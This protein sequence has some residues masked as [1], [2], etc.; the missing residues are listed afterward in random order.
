M[1]RCPKCGR[2]Y[3]D[4]DLNFCYEDGELLSYT[5]EDAPA[6]GHTGRPSVTD[7][8]P[9]TE[10]LPSARVTSEDPW[11]SRQQPPAV[12]QPSQMDGPFSQFPTR[13]VPNQT[14]GIVAL[15]LG[16]SSLTIG[17]CCSSGFVLS[18]AALIVGF[19]ALSQIKKDPQ[20]YGG[21]GLALGGIVTA[22]IY[23]VIYIVIIMI[24]ILALIASSAAG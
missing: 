19:I 8:P 12:W 7:E 22:A 21:K 23:L 17:W 2:T 11:A 10:F 6:S 1:K 18:P 20:R 14:L 3:T 5:A 15:I 9:P 13:V 4:K 24:Y 16:I